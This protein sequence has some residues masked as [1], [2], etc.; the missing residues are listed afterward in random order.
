MEGEFKGFQK[1]E[2]NIQ[3]HR[4]NA[5]KVGENKV[6]KS[7]QGNIIR[8][9]VKLLPL[10]TPDVVLHPVLRIRIFCQIGSVAL[11]LDQKK[12]FLNSI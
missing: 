5:I 9:L 7:E 11:Y 4:V 3:E 10:C 2:G 6:S 12:D 8:I 1:M